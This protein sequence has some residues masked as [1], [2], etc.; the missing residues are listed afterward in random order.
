MRETA[1]AEKASLATWI[2][3]EDLPWDAAN[4]LRASA[5]VQ[6]SE[7]DPEAAGKMPIPSTRLFALSTIDD[8]TVAPDASQDT[9]FFSCAPP[10]ENATSTICVEAAP[11]RL[12]ATT[13]RGAW[14]AASAALPFWMAGF[15]QAR[16]PSVVPVQ[17]ELL[18]LAR[19]LVHRGFEPTI[20]G[21]IKETERGAEV[22]GRA[23]E[24]AIVAV[25]AAPQA[26]WAVPYT[27]GPAWSLDGEPRVVPLAPGARVSLMPPAGSAQL[28]APLDARRTIVFRRST[29]TEKK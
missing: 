16:E 13:P 22:L 19:K 3:A 6:V 26:P 1:T 4:A 23:G 12:H 2:A 8:A 9:I 25:G 15:T 7:L 24:D 28:R 5:V 10:L 14:G 18:A 17:A 20:L 29:T 21:A 27:D 11:Q